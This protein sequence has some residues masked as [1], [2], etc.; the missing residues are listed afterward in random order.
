MD[1]PFGSL[2]PVTRD[3]LQRVY[4]GLH[5][6]LGLTTLLVTHDV[7]EALLLADRVIC[8]HEGRVLVS[9]PPRE[10]LQ[11]PQP[12]PVSRLLDIPRRQ[13]QRLERLVRG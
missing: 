6:E 10:L 5:E 11:A 8:L 9:A 3:Q 2:D 4:R 7:V 12:E 13:T 1:E